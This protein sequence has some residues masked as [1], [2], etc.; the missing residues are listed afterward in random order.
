M[1]QQVSQTYPD[2]IA[3]YDP[4]AKP[5]V[6]ISYRDIFEQINAFGAG[7]RSLGLQFGDMVAL[8]ADNSPRWLIADQ[9]ILAIG[10]ANA[11]R[12]SQAER[13]ELLYIIEH[14]DSVAIVIENLAT[15]K[16]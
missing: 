13:R 6:R 14:S 7:L 2:A 8:I 9:G 5:P 15:L 11:T 4:H 3:L 16:N 1:W 10:A 12:S